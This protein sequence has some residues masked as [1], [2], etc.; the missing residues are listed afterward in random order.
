MV[1][2][3]KKQHRGLVVAAMSGGVDSSVAASLML[4]M[5]YDVVGVT[6]TLRSC[7]DPDER[8]KSCCASDDASQ[9]ALSAAALGIPHYFRD[10]R[11]IFKERV[12]RPSWTEY[13]SGRTPNPCVLCNRVVKFGALLDFALELGAVGM[14]TGHYCR[15]ERNPDGSVKLFKGVD[16]KKDQS[17][18]LAALTPRQLQKTFFPL[19]GMTKERVREIAAELGLPNSDKQESQDACFGRPGETFAQT[20]GSIFNSKPKRGFVRDETGKALVKHDGIHNFTIGQRR[21]LG[22]ALGKPAF[23]SKIDPVDGD[24]VVSTD[25]SSLLSDDLLCDNLNWINPVPDSFKCEVKIRYQT[26]PLPASFERLPDGRG[27]VSFKTPAK[28]VTPGQIIA[29]YDKSKLLGGGVIL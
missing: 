18:F 14:A 19:G 1:T 3:E 28:S 20:L 5:G 10:A 4:D 15:L 21:G 23:V 11:E 9:A 12:L 16:P 7:D 27:K 26:P 17:Y 6:L 13:S 2:D 25:P 29:F 22:V 8:R 24:V